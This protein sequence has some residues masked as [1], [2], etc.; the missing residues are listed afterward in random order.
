M[1]IVSIRELDAV[2]EQQRAGGV[3]P[4]GHTQVAD[5]FLM[6]CDMVPQERRVLAGKM[7][8]YDAA[9][10]DEFAQMIIDAVFPP[11][12]KAAI[13]AQLVETIRDEIDTELADERLINDTM[14]WGAGQLN[15][16]EDYYGVHLP[17]SA[18]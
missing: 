11:E 2:C 10:A 16:E 1:S 14:E 7:A 12:R 15:D 5:V 8:A 3:T 4:F 18:Q 13:K 6:W 17:A 9:A